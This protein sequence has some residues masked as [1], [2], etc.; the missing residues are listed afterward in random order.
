[1]NDQTT[2]G[3][4]ETEDLGLGTNETGETTPGIGHNSGNTGDIL[5]AYIE[6]VERLIEERKA[7]NGDISEIMSEAKGNGFDPKIIRRVIALRAKDRAD[8]QEEHELIRLYGKAI[9]IEDL[10]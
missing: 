9:G 5:K 2:P 10:L 8:R 1:M 7:I 6:R 4:E 3:I